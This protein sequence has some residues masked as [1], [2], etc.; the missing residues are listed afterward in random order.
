M[1]SVIKTEITVRIG[2][3]RLAYK[4]QLAK[5]GMEI[6]EVWCTAVFDVCQALGLSDEQTVLASGPVAWMLLGAGQEE[7]DGT[8]ADL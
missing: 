5:V 7:E 3:M 2:E 6:P 4:E 8:K 1:D